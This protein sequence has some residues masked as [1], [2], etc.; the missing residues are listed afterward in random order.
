MHTRVVLRV[1]LVPTAEHPWGAGRAQGP[2]LSL[3]RAQGRQWQ[4]GRWGQAVMDAAQPVAAWAGVSAGSCPRADLWLAAKGLQGRGLDKSQ[5]E[6]FPA[7]E[8]LG[9]GAWLWRR[10]RGATKI[11]SSAQGGVPGSQEHQG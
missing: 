8:R 6:S 7:C 11:R 5:R 4:W 1:P 10:P 2:L 3:S 9:A